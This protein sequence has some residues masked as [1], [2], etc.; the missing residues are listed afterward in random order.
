MKRFF[1]E[2]KVFFAKILRSTEFFEV[3]GCVAE[4][5]EGVP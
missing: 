5:F 3:I 1:P 4:T 2:Q